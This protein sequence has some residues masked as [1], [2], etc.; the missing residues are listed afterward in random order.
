[1]PFFV[2][3]IGH[4]GARLPANWLANEAWQDRLR[5]VVFPKFPRSVTR[6]S[7][8][9]YYGAGT[10]RFCAVLEVI[11]DEPDQTRGPGSDR[12]PYEL[13]VRPLIAIP[14]DEHAPS[15]DELGFDPL[16][17]RRQ[18]HVRLDAD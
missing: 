10:R 17:L 4:A 5:S 13:L 11:S 6:G 3:T 14:A 12:W 18:S 1:M 16:R 7:R 2:K 9:I 8:L 15:L